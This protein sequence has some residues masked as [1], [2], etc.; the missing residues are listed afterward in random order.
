MQSYTFSFKNKHFV[1]NILYSKLFC[2]TLHPTGYIASYNINTMR[3]R[4][5]TIHDIP[6]IQALAEVAF[7]HTYRE[8]LSPEQME[9]MMEWMYS[10]KSLHEQMDD[11]GHVFLIL[12]ADNG[13]DIG[14]G[15]FNKEGK[16][17]DRVLFHLQKIYVLPQMQGK[18]YGAA[19]FREMEKEMLRRVHPSAVTF[20]LNVNRNNRAVTFYEHLGMHKNRVGDFHI[21]NGFYMNDYIMAKELEAGSL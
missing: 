15:S 6:I 1:K 8:I 9:Y 3:I 10:T 21:G 18:G 14:Y 13:E 2:L 4:Q 16:R 7:R 19:L 12:T 5:A 11:N 20:E 17:G